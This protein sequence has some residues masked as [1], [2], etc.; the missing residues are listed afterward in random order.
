MVYPNFR[1]NSTEIFPGSRDLDAGFS[2][3]FSHISIVICKAEQ[4][5]L[6]LQATNFK[7]EEVYTQ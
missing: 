1:L 6:K 4:V 5:Y 3:F 7:I 2:V